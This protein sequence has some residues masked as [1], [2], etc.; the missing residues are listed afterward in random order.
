MEGGSQ[1]Q[2]VQTTRWTIASSKKTPKESNKTEILV[3]LL[4]LEVIRV[5]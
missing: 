1:Q 3:N 4:H 2:E 5:D